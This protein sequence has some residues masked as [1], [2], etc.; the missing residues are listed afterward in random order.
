MAMA[1]EIIS[2]F[3]Q[4]FLL[5][6]LPSCLAYMVSRSSLALKDLKRS[7]NWIILFMIGALKTFFNTVQLAEQIWRGGDVLL[8]LNIV[9]QLYIAFYFV[10]GMVVFDVYLSTLLSKVRILRHYENHDALAGKAEEVINTFGSVKTST[11]PFLLLMF[12]YSVLQLVNGSY[13][14]TTPNGDKSNKLIG[15]LV[16]SISC[17]YLCTSCQDCH[18]TLKKNKM[19]LR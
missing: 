12:C 8:I 14:L 1:S 13:L 15:F 6:T 10:L 18:D 9:A 16:N 5:F 11:G 3:L 17:F 2:K 4:L 19:N 7:T